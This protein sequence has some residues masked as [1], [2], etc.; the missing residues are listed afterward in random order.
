MVGAVYF[1]AALG[2]LGEKAE[3]WQQFGN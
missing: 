1:L 2:E 3:T